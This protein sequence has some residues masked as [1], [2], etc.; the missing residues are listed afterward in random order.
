[1]T[2]GI[3]YYELGRQTGRMAKEILVDGKNPKD[4]PV[5]TIEKTTKIVNNSS[6]IKLEL[7]PESEV[8]SGATFIN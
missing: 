2:D 4:M 7:S 8:F 5:E 1:M 3:S 6:L